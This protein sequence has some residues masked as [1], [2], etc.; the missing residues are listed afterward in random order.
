MKDIDKKAKEILFKTYWT[1]AGWRDERTVSP[2]DY[3]YAKAKGLM[4]DPL[5]ISHDECVREIIKAANKITSEQTAKA[6]LSSLSARRL[7][8]RSGISSYY[9]AKL[10]TPHKYKPVVSGYYYEGGKVVVTSYTCGICKDTKYGVI[11]NE[12]YRDTDLNVLNFER[13]KWGGVRHGELIYIYFDL[14]QF[15]KEEIPDPTDKDFDILKGILSAAVSCDPNDYPGALRDKLKGVPGLKASKAERTVL[16]EILAAIGVLKPRSYDRP[17]RSK[18]DWTFIEYWRGEDGYDPEAVK[19]YFG[20]Y[21]NNES[22][23]G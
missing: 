12:I 13:I 17:V 2:E 23:G 4:F 1:S 14:Q 19:E 16:L 9:F 21:L 18:H 5:T 6:F 7:D 8:W 20:R 22:Y 10:F 11:G 3:L 15:L